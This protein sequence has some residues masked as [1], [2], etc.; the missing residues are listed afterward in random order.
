[1]QTPSPYK[2]F[3]NSI[4]HK[5]I[6]G[7]T[8]IEVTVVLVIVSILL[9]Y[10]VS[11]YPAQQEV[12]QYTT[13][14]EEM[15]SIV[16]Y[17]IRFAQVN[18]RLPCPDSTAGGGS[19]N[20]E[21]NLTASPPPPWA[22]VSGYAYLPG[23]TLGVQGHYDDNGRLLDP[24]GQPYRYAVSNGTGVENFID[25]DNIKIQGLDNMNGNIRVCDDSPADLNETNCPPGTR[26]VMSRVAAIVLSTGKDAGNSTSLIQAE[27]LDNFNSTATL[28]RL[29]VYALRSDR[30]S[31]EYD[32]LVRWVSTTQLL[33]KL[34]EAGR[35]P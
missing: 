29:F 24:W 9:G 20:G 19:F 35:L 10:T 22:C 5:A 3:C 15:D 6:S 30:S 34:V 27:N 12:K 25:R 11:I 26:E 21:E 17:I 33:S 13:A 28:D 18:G 8:L 32:D 1:M 31:A 16:K 14:N 4:R 23:K 7:F 2:Y